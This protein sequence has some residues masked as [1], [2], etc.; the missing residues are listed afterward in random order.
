MSRENRESFSSE[1][2]PMGSVEKTQNKRIDSIELFRRNEWIFLMMKRFHEYD[3][4]SNR[5]IPAIKWFSMET[6]EDE[7]DGSQYFQCELDKLLTIWFFINWQRPTI[8]GF[9]WWRIKN[10][11]WTNMNKE[12][13]HPINSEAIVSRVC[14]GTIRCT[15][16]H[17]RNSLDGPVVSFVARARPGWA[18]RAGL[19]KRVRPPATGWV[20][21]RWGA[22]ASSRGGTTPRRPAPEWPGLFRP[23]LPPQP[24]TA[25]DW[26]NW[27]K[28]VRTEGQT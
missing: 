7:K 25:D 9:Y 28:S 8:S 10:N 24:A 27:K 3:W 26:H 19:S 1:L 18:V 5:W 14:E 13:S 22:I 6:G 23:R 4:W 20:M 17:S 21:P 15:K 12:I 11:Q 2:N 16:T